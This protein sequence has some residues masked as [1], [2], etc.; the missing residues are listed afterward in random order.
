VRTVSSVAGLALAAHLVRSMGGQIWFESERDHGTTV[1]FT[2]RLGMRAADLADDAVAPGQLARRPPGSSSGAGLDL[3]VVGDIPEDRREATRALEERGHRV[4]VAS[5]GPQALG[6]VV[7]TPFDAVLLNL[8]MPA[9]DG[10]EL[11]AVLRTLEGHRGRRL[12]IV[13]LTAMVLAGDLERCAAAGIDACLHKP[14]DGD[15]VLGTLVGLLSSPRRLSVPAE[16]A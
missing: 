9:M 3:L 16:S 12:P 1:R 8:R 10:F 15:D 13:A 6:M 5:D 11:A 4:V 2:M 14:R 7:A